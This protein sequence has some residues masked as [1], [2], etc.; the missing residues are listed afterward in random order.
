MILKDISCGCK[1]STNARAS[2]AVIGKIA[3]KLPKKV[4]KIAAYFHYVSSAYQ[5][6]WRPSSYLLV[7][8]YA[9]IT[10]NFASYDDIARSTCKEK[11]QIRPWQ[12]EKCM[13]CVVTLFWPQT[14]AG[15]CI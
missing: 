8:K 11:L 9:T 5:N 3:I 13:I 7:Y 12:I 15:L 10:H 4:L 2:Y 6:V 1:C 14:D